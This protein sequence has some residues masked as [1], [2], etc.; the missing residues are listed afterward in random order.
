MLSTNLLKKSF[1]AL[2]VVTLT[3]VVGASTINATSASGRHKDSD[4]QSYSKNQCLHDGWK[5]FKN[6][7]GS[8]RFKNQGQCIS[9][10]NH[11][12]KQED[13][14]EHGKNKGGDKDH[15]STDQEHKASTIQAPAI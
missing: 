12:D 8:Q 5:N 6:P 2:S 4:E 11:E 1:V 14:G 7:N 10:F 3:A 13:R 9:F 15:G